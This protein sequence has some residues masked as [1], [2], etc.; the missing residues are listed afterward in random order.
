MKII[1]I[2]TDLDTGGAEMMLYKLLS[3]MQE[4]EM[5]FLVISLMNQGGLSK[6]IES[7]GVTVK[8]LGL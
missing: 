1:H 4:E 5:E 3:S 8:V 6:H 7:L 2:I